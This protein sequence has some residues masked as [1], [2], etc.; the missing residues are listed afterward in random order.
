MGSLIRDTDQS[1]SSKI[2]SC[3]EK[4][5]LERSNMEK[6][7]GKTEKKMGKMEKKVERS[8]MKKKKQDPKTL[9]ERRTIALE[10]M[11]DSANALVMWTAFSIVA[12]IAIATVA[13]ES[14]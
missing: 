6:K 5:T 11:A 8:K 2:S 12:V 13:K 9:E 1:T 4:K 10:R 14:N 3:S 7:M